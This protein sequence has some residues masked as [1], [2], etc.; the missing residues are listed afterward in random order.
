MIH[1][2]DRIASLPVKV[3]VNDEGKYGR[4]YYTD[5]PWA[6][7]RVYTWHEGKYDVKA[8]VEEVGEWNEMIATMFGALKDAAQ[9][10][11]LDMV[12]PI[13]DFPDL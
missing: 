7:K 11:G 1:L 10:N 13:A 12:G 4:S 8:L 5:D 3:Y 2:L 9:A 6:K